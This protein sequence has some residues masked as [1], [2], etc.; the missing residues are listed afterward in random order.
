[1]KLNLNIGDLIMD[2]GDSEIGTVVSVG[3][4][5]FSGNPEYEG[6]F[7]PSW[8]VLWPSMGGKL[9]DVGEDDFLMGDFKIVSKA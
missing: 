2:M 5:L 4:G 3:P 6:G 7:M 1:V 9:F 8:K